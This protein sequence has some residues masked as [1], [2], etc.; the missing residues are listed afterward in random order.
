MTM[1]SFKQVEVKHGKKEPCERGCSRI[2]SF[3]TAWIL[4]TENMLLFHRFEMK[5]AVSVKWATFDN[6]LRKVNFILIFFQ[7]EL[8]SLLSMGKPFSGNLEG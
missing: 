5:I 4:D 1:P 2:I 7:E 3:L 6:F 8:A